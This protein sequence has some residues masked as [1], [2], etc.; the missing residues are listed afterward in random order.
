MTLQ[1]VRKPPFGNVRTDRLKITLDGNHTIK[2]KIGMLLQA[3]FDLHEGYGI[4][5]AGPTDIYILLIDPNGYP[6]THFSDGR[7]ICDYN[8]II[9]SPYHCAADSYQP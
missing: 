3:K 7:P 2:Q 6:L 1:L 4:D 5:F 9:K 8:G